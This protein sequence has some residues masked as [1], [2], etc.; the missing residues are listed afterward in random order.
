MIVFAE[1]QHDLESEP[2][3]LCLLPIPNLAEGERL[4]SAADYLSN[5]RKA[6][7]VQQ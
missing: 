2:P 7:R 6:N 3:V 1:F 5:E 4:G